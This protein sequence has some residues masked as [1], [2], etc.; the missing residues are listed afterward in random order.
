MY[1]PEKYP[2]MLK[3]YSENIVSTICVCTANTL[4]STNSKPTLVFRAVEYKPLN[5]EMHSAII[6]ENIK[7]LKSILGRAD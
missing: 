4:F 7:M 1:I 3:N 6:K 5:P 2:F